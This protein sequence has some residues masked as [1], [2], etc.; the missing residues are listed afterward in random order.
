MSWSSWAKSIAK[1][2][3]R[4]IDKVLEINEGELAEGEIREIA[5]NPNSSNSELNSTNPE[6]QKTIEIGANMTN[7]GSN[8]KPENHTDWEQDWEN[9]NSKNENSENQNRHPKNNTQEEQSP[10]TS[11]SQS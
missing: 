9:E 4:G 6:K 10:K 7:G 3:Q 11:P 8:Y 2:A 1:E 5:E